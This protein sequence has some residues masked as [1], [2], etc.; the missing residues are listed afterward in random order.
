MFMNDHTCDEEKLKAMVKNSR[1]QLADPLGLQQPLEGPSMVRQ[2]VEHQQHEPVQVSEEFTC[3]KCQE[4]F[5]D[6]SSFSHH[7]DY[8]ELMPEV[9]ADFRQQNNSNALS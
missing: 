7:L 6:I 2:A 5:T 9:Q 1:G 8:H 3:D 4:K